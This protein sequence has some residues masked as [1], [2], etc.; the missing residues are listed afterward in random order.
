MV[1]AADASVEGDWIVG[2]VSLCDYCAPFAF[3]SD[4]LYIL[5]GKVE[6]YMVSVYKRLQTFNSGFDP[7]IAGK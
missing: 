6:N 1:W 5:E 3:L 4:D 7:Y 2:V